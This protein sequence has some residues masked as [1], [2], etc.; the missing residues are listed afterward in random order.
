MKGRFFI[1][2]YVPSFLLK[3]MLGEVSIELLKSASVSSE[4]ISS[5]GFQFVF[6]SLEVALDELL[7]K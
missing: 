2:G 4:K 6:P 3:M 7:K 5:T 1:P